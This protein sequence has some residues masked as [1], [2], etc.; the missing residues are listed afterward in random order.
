MSSWWDR[1]LNNGLP[2]ATPEAQQ[3]MV[4][5]QAPQF[6]PRAQPAGYPASPGY[7]PPPPPPQQIIRSIPEAMMAVRD[8]VTTGSWQGKNGVRDRVIEYDPLGDPVADAVD[9]CPRCHSGNVFSRGW[10]PD[11]KNRYSKP[12]K[13]RCFDCGWPSGDDT[14]GSVAPAQGIPLRAARQ[15]PSDHGVEINLNSTGSLRYFF[16]PSGGR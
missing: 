8:A 11:G 10:T 13:P 3:P 9:R 14:V 2:Q 15:L 1:A 16:P 7:V 4:L 5:P 6:A 12:P